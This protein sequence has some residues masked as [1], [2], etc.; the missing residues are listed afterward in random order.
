MRALPALLLIGLMAGCQ[1]ESQTTAATIKQEPAMSSKDEKQTSLVF[2]GTVKYKSFEGG[3]YAIDAQN[4]EK[5]HPMGLA[6]EYR[7]DGLI[8]AVEAQAITD[9]MTI[10]QY[11]TPIK[12]LSI[13][14]IDD[15]QV[16]QK[17]NE[18]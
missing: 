2:Q 17:G 9:L 14:I 5:Y 3:F 13:R 12:I 8:V 16:S 11:G 18:Q 15:T 7:R 10:Q 1:T 6:K 4:G